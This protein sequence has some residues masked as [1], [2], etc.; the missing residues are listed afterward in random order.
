MAESCRWRRAS[1]ESAAFC[2]LPM[3]AAPGTPDWP[4]TLSFCRC[5]IVSRLFAFGVELEQAADTRRAASER[6]FIFCRLRAGVVQIMSA[7][8]RLPFPGQIDD[9]PQA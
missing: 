2:A 3:A 4:K 9:R 8:G 1:S 6:R 5:V 7:Y